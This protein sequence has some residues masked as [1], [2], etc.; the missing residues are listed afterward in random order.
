MDDGMFIYSFMIQSVFGDVEYG[1]PL[2]ME[3]KNGEISVYEE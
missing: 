3:L 2:Y 1:D